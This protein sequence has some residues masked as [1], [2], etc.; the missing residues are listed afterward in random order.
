MRSHFKPHIK[1]LIRYQTS[2]GRDLMEGLRLDRNEKIS[3]FPPEIVNDIFNKFKAY[4][5]SASPDVEVLYKKIANFLGISK[6]MIYVTAGITECI[7]ILYETLTNP[8]E[9]AI[10]LHPTYPFYSIYAKMYQIEYRKFSFKN[11]LTP[12]WN[13]L[14]HGLDD[15]TTM[16]MIPN[17]NLPVECVFNEEEVR[18]IAD[19]CKEHNTVLAIDEAYHYFGAP[20]VIKL[21][22][23]YDNLVVMRTFS[24]AFGLAGLRL[25]FM[26]SAPENI[27]YL[28]K[29]RPLVESNTLSTGIA[30][31]MLDHPE[32]M[33]NHVREVKEGSE[34]LQKEF[35]KLGL[36]WF[37]GNYTNGILVFLD[38]ESEVYDLIG[39]LKKRK[40]YIRGAFEPPYNVCIRVSI[41]QREMMEIFIK[42]LKCWLEQGK[43]HN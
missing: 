7:R 6:E 31:Y 18:S 17:P 35:T 9:N 24:K 39:Y 20:T 25:G 27:E 41:G 1:N 16:V 34:Y 26:I 12:D 3:N 4:S 38:S 8:G 42:A 5:L 28:S 43:K 2:V 14:H 13:S 40:I 29:T 33:Q 37:G 30:E 10:V 22:N 21:I 23:E 11:D 19:K 15:K 36:K 32:H